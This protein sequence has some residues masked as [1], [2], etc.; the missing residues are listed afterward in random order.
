MSPHSS[1]AVAKEIV[2]R[3]QKANF[4]AFWVGGCVREH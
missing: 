2:E 4:A 3:L 1:K